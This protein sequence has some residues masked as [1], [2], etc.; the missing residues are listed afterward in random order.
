MISDEEREEIIAAAV[1]R[2]LLKIPEVVGNLITSQMSM[3]NINKEFYKSHPEFSNK[4]EVVQSVVEMVEGK[5][6]GLGYEEILKKAIPE[7]RERIGI[8]SK[9]NTNNV[10][11]PNRNLANLNLSNGE[12]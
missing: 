3:L 9:L 11:K 2:T 8:T 5:N 7:I 1:E 12:L 4:R 6:A 10:T